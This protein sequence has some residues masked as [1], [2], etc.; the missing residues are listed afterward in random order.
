MFQYQFKKYD[1]ISILLVAALAVISYYAIGSATRVNSI[2]G[3]DRF[4]N[5]QFYGYLLGFVLMIIVSFIDYHLIGKFAIL[6]YLVNIALL[7]AV[8]VVGKEAKGAMRWIEVGGSFSIQPSEFAKLFMIIVLAKY[9]DKFESKI[10]KIYII[11]GS[12]ILIAIPFILIEKQ[13]DLSTSLVFIFLF[14]VLIFTAGISYK[15]IIA[16][17]LIMIP[18]GFGVF[19]YIQQE[20]QQLLKGYQLERILAIVNPE[21]Y[22][23]S[24]ALQTENSKQAIGSGGLYGKGLYQGKLNQYDYLPEPQTDFIFSVIGEEFGFVGCSAVLIILFL[25]MLRAIFIAK[26]SPDLMG[27]LLVTGFVAII[28]FHTFIN[29]GVTTGIVPNTGLPLPFISYGQNAL[30]TNMTMLGMVINLSMQRKISL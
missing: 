27:Q 15:Y 12:V 18:I 2:E 24:T 9:F 29:V 13:P 14:A 25:L 16:L 1:F 5:R 28:F 7:A 30:W 8:F 20:D 4:V 23:L 17:V 6:I 22:E 26:D 19:W 3:T 11:L 10:N 21:E